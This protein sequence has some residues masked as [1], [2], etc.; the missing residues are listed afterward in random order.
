MADLTTLA[1]VKSYVGITSSADDEQLTSLITAY[2]EWARS[3]MSRD[4]TV[5]SYV[6]WSSGRGGVSMLVREWPIVSVT[7]LA[8]EGVTIPAAPAWNAYGYRFA[9]RSIT[10]SGGIIFPIGFDNVRVAYSAGFAVIP[11]DIAQAINELVGLR[12]KMRDKIEWSSK[13]LAGETVS[14]VTK[15]MP[16]SVR[17][18]LRNYT[19]VVPV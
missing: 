8:I 14:L 6:S 11:A 18:V 1:A 2:S 10:L 15:D 7:A 4:I 16:D 19:N 3:V 17:T 5:Q 12:Y 13:S 9:E